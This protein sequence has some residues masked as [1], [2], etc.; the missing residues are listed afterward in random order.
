VISV[1]AGTGAFVKV[2][3]KR[4]FHMLSQFKKDGKVS[5]HFLSVVMT[6]CAAGFGKMYWHDIDGEYEFDS[7]YARGGA[8]MADS[9]ANGLCIAADARDSMRTR[10]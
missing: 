2:D 9:V 7:T 6:D 5:T 3:G 10:Q 1:K 8:S 4:A